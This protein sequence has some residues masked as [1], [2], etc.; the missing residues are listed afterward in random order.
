M[1]GKYGAKLHIYL[2]ITDWKIFF[3]Q[4]IA[5]LIHKKNRPSCVVHRIMAKNQSLDF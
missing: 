3:I 5:C 4:N 2:E 1:S